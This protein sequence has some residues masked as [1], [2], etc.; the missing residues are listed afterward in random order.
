MEK[1]SV[2]D[3]K[4]Q[5]NLN[6]YKKT[7]ETLKQELKEKYLKE[8]E[9]IEA[10]SEYIRTTGWILNGEK[11]YLFVKKEE[12]T[13]NSYGLAIVNLYD[14]KGTIYKG[15]INDNYENAFNIYKNSFGVVSRKYDIRT[16][17][18]N[19]FIFRVMN[20]PDYNKIFSFYHADYDKKIFK[21]NR[22]IDYVD[23]HYND[24]LTDMEC[25]HYSE[26]KVKWQYSM[27]GNEIAFEQEQNRLNNIKRDKG[28]LEKSALSKEEKKKILKRNNL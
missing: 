8:V 6:V 20:F 9:K 2:L 18:E 22:I 23:D 15:V 14:K 1:L 28:R 27:E 16:L 10:E 3:N 12:I 26:G 19:E 21:Q 17:H 5:Q 7:L 24:Y 4:Y 13:F 11:I 25:Y